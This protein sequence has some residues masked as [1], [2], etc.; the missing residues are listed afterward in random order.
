MDF[1]L[2]D[3]VLHFN[4]GKRGHAATFSRKRLDVGIPFHIYYSANDTRRICASVK[5]NTES[6]KKKR[7]DNLKGYNER[8]KRTITNRG[9]GLFIV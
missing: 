2:A 4:D 3:S 5:K 8:T 1:A 6:K 9:R 7:L